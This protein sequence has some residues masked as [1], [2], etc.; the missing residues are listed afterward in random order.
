M[1]KTE[2]LTIIIPTFN[3]PEGL[4]KQ[5]KKLLEIDCSYIYEVIILDNDSSLSFDEVTMLVN[6]SNKFSLKK[7]NFNI[8]MASNIVQPFLLCKTEWL[9][10]LSDDDEIYDDSVKNIEKV[11]K[12]NKDASFIKFSNNQNEIYE[13]DESLS[14]LKE[15]VN[16]F[17]HNNRNSRSRIGNF[18]FLSTSIFNMKKL[19]K[20]LPK[21]F[22]YSYSNIG[23]IICIIFALDDNKKMIFSSLP[24]AKYIDPEENNYS[25]TKIAKGMTVLS[26]MDL[27]ISPKVK[28]Q[29]MNII[30]TLR[31]MSVFRHILKY[32]QK[33]SIQEL[34]EIKHF[35]FRYFS[36]KDKMYIKFFLFIFPV[37]K[38]VYKIY[39]NN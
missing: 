22:E 36:I 8:G 31:P 26:H 19:H 15:F 34:K 29:L 24:I 1:Y 6:E 32:P 25:Y 7:N 9:W 10:I 23:H 3:R 5:V 33:N 28:R 35:Y 14:S 17:N 4:L 12:N 21:S 37:I 16:Y 27:N 13:N 18:V 38:Y 30:F 39:K 11:T 20:Y 2:Q